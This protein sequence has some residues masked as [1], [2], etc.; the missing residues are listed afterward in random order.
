[1]WGPG[2]L[3]ARIN[4]WLLLGKWR[5]GLCLC[6]HSARRN[7]VGKKHKPSWGGTQGR[8]GVPKMSFGGPPGPPSA[9]DTGDTVG[10]GLCAA[11][12][13]DLGWERTDPR[14]CQQQAGCRARVRA[15][16]SR[17]NYMGLCQT[18]SRAL[19]A[20][21]GTPGAPRGPAG[22][23]R[24]RAAHAGRAPLVRPE[25][26]QTLRRQPAPC[27]RGCN[28]GT[29]TRMRPHRPPAHA[30]APRAARTHLP[31]AR[32]RERLRPGHAPVRPA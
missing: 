23:T 8:Q 31:A 4:L 16:G 21:R 26:A 7:S 28:S 19:P 6:R 10:G 14:G 11:D 22:I 27:P 25:R 2:R 1:M 12:I 30:C 3:E 17:E 5:R 24:T 15:T 20:P 32:Q 29:R 18:Q 9:E 13:A